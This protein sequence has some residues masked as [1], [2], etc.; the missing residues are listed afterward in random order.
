[1]AQTEVGRLIALVQRTLDFYRPSQGRVVATQVNQLIENVLALSDKRLA[2]AHIQVNTELQ[3]DLPSI[4]VVPDQLTQVLLNLTINAIEAMPEGGTLSITTMT[5]DSG[6]QIVVQDTGTGLIPDE[7]AK[8]FEPFYTTKAY[9]TGLGL[10][11][12][13]GIIQQHGGRIAVDSAPGAGTT[14]TV[15]LPLNRSVED[16]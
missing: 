16:D 12:S 7:A 13:Y 15:Q 4:A 8:I 5:S 14:F 6:L 1:M 11:V 2:H 10:A 9:G 3:P